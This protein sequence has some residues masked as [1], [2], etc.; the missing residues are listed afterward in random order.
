MHILYA[1][2]IGH[3][4]FYRLSYFSR[5][6]VLENMVIYVGSTSVH[7]QETRTFSINLHFK[8]DS[9]QLHLQAKQTSYGRRLKIHRIIVPCIS[10]HR[11]SRNS[12]ISLI[13]GMALCSRQPN[14]YIIIFPSPIICFPPINGTRISMELSQNGLDPVTARV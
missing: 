6:F 5:K 4:L 11:K 13:A 14:S 8:Y 3:K 9:P 10:P 1:T 2:H 12:I 7:F